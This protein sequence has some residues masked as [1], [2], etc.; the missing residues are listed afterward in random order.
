MMTVLLD[1][2]ANPDAIKIIV[3]PFPGEPVSISKRD[4]SNLLARERKERHYPVN[5]QV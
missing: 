1:A 4:A 3:E 5:K 2:K